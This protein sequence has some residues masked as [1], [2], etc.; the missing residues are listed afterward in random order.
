MRVVSD[1]VVSCKPN[2][3]L[4]VARWRG[5]PAAPTSPSFSACNSAALNSIGRRRFSSSSM[6]SPDRVYSGGVTLPL[7]TELTL[8][9]P[10]EA[11]CGKWPVFR[12]INEDGKI[13]DENGQVG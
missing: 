2:R 4:R 5:G 7:T 11:P 6:D 1:R 3:L 9:E 12:V 10:H 13:R 8:S